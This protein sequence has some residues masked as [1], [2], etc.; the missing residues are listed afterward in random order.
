MKFTQK[1]IKYCLLSFDK[2]T[3]DHIEMYAKESLC[4]SGLYLWG[5]IF[6]GDYNFPIFSKDT[7]KY[8]LIHVNITPSNIPLVSKLLPMVNRNIT[9]LIFN[10]DHSVD[11]WQNTFMYPHLLL[12]TLDKADYVF[13]VEENMCEIL[14]NSLK[15]NV[16]CIPHPVEINKIKE[17]SHFDRDQRIGVSIHRYT[18]NYL[19]PW[20]AIKDI[21]DGWIT[22]AIGANSGDFHPKIHHL[23]PEVQER[24]AFKELMKYVS[25][26]YAMVESYNISSYGRLTAECAALAVPVVGCGM[27]GSQKR[28]FPKLTIDYFEPIKIGKLLN[29]LINDVDFWT[30]C[31]K[32]AVKEC[33]YY[34]VENSEKRMLN[35]L[36][37]E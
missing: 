29:K 30:E 6:K 11:L 36:N 5:K 16:P 37:K 18:G 23:Y 10:V 1:N 8:N 33:A 4:I 22:S 14:T 9:K 13:G 25:T 19:L 27:V 31:V 20:Y 3:K 28:C 21:P 26:L 35:F 24:L 17:Y 7:E 2:P 34:S 32:E 12:E 15:R